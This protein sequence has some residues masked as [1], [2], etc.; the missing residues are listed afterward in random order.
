MPG[1]LP[2]TDAA[3]N[4]T[5]QRRNAPTIPT[6]DV[7]VAGY[8]GDIPE[9][10]EELGEL[11]RRYYDRA[12]RTPAAAAW[13][14]GEAEVVA[15]WANLKA[16]VSRLRQAGEVPPASLLGQLKALADALY[17]SPLARAK[18]RVRV[19]DTE[20]VE[21]DDV[22]ELDDRFAGVTVVD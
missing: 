20:P 13:L 11:A 10:L 6:T 1:P 19:V 4:P 21:V 2:H 22:L 3:G 7:P 15:E 5:A 18:G 16:D 12:W 8:T 9:P 14:E 17:L